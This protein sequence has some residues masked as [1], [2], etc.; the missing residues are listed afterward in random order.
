MP[1]GGRR[2]VWLFRRLV[3]WRGLV[4]CSNELAQ[5]LPDEDRAEGDDRG[6]ENRSVHGSVS[7]SLR[8][9][10]R[11]IGAEKINGHPLRRFGSLDLAAFDD[12]RP[13]QVIFAFFSHWAVLIVPVYRS[14]ASTYQSG[15]AERTSRDL[16]PSQDRS[17]FSERGGVR[18]SIGIR[19]SSQASPSRPPRSLRCSIPQRSLQR[20]DQTARGD[21]RACKSAPFAEFHR[22]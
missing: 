9:T 4:R 12:D 22:F 18:R 1:L 11:L 14:A 2:R 21:T 16:S 15:A 13:F 6:V 17:T 20:S 3:F 7:I 10:S 5:A 19:G 8:F